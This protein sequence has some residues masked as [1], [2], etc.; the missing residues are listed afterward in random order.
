MAARGLEGIG[1]PLHFVLLC[2]PPWVSMMPFFCSFHQN[3]VVTLQDE[4]YSFYLAI[5]LVAHPGAFMN[6]RK[7]KQNLLSLFLN[8]LFHLPDPSPPPRPPPCPECVYSEQ[9]FVLT[10]ISVLHG[11]DY[12]FQQRGVAASRSCSKESLSG[13]GAGDL[14]SPA[15]SG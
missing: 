9:E 2:D 6:E 5:L 13:C 11:C 8:M 3:T 7:T 4:C 1:K 14:Q 15:L 12:R 10:G